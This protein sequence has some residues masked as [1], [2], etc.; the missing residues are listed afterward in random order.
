MSASPIAWAVHPA[1]TPAY[2]RNVQLIRRFFDFMSTP[3]L[4]PWAFRLTLFLQRFVPPPE[5]D[6]RVSIRKIQIPRN[7]EF[8]LDG[9]SP[10]L[11]EGV[12]QAEVISFGPSNPR[13]VILYLQGGGYVAGCPKFARGMTWRLAKHSGAR[14]VALSYRLAPTNTYPCAL[15]DALSAYA[16]LRKGEAGGEP[17]Q[18][19]FCG[20]SAGGGLAVATA[21][22]I[23]DHGAQVGL[24]MPAG[25]AAMSPWL[26]LSSST[27]SYQTNAPFD[28]LPNNGHDQ[29]LNADRSQYYVADNSVLRHP[30]VSPYYAKENGG[31]P[32]C[33]MMIQ[34]GECERFR[35]ES[36]MFALNNFPMS[37]IQ[38]EMYEAMAHM[39]Q[40]MWDTDDFFLFRLPLRGPRPPRHSLRCI[41]SGRASLGRRANLLSDQESPAAH[42]SPTEEQRTKHAIAEE[43]VSAWFDARGQPQRSLRSRRSPPTLARPASPRAEP[44]RAPVQPPQD[45]SSST[46]GQKRA[47]R[48]SAQKMVS[49]LSEVAERHSAAGREAADD[50]AW[51]VGS[52]FAVS[53]S[54]TQLD[55][56]DPALPATTDAKFTPKFMRAAATSESRALGLDSDTLPSE[57]PSASGLLTPEAIMHT[58]RAL[59]A[60]NPVVLDVRDR[61]DWTETLIIAESRSKKQLYT[62][63]D[64]VRR[65]A[66]RYV[67]TDPALASNLVVE[68]AQTEDWMVLDL[69]RCVVHVMTPEARAFYDLEGLWSGTEGQAGEN[70]L[71]NEME[72]AQMIEMVERAWKDRPTTL[73][74]TKQIEAEDLFG[75]DDVKERMRA[76]KQVFGRRK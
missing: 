76:P 23:R 10:A 63:A 69:G 14:V 13:A 58:L 42:Q 19:V 74:K 17:V 7:P 35:D 68:G 33:P 28:Y 60:T 44:R 51:F 75:V 64:A 4:G 52:S 26:D 22:W 67:P 6:P 41:F 43:F 11:R 71:T 30:Y 32:L 66:K 50:D 12:M 9:L 18:V 54:G 62:L 29:I 73:V 70:E 15:H 65:L 49:Q 8:H 31:Q 57:D 24:E 39:F 5:T 16:F 1:W 47:A 46:L 25:V 40:D 36:L 2:T 55:A 21:L 61:C 53:A 72:E 3:L 56:S 38:L 48:S 27:L 59:R 20:D 34:V 45:L 37:P